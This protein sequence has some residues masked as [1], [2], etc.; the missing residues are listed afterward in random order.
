MIS[1]LWEFT[2]KY[3][4]LI[5]YIIVGGCTTVVSMLLFY[6]SVWFILDANDAMQLQIA[7]V[8]SWIGSVLFAYVT[9]R[10][11]VF[12]SKNSQIVKEFVN[13]VSSRVFTLLL[14][15]LVMFILATLVGINYN[16]A[17]IVSMLLVTIGNYIISKVFVF[18]KTN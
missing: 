8:I 5:V 13:F 6:G 9:N 15:M 10:E 3:K 4:E 14:D 11:F 18:K 16:F 1:N 7:N 17:K 12:K 2:K